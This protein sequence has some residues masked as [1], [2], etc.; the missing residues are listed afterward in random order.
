[1]PKH[2]A[3]LPAFPSY[4][5]HANHMVRRSIL[6]CQSVL[7]SPQDMTKFDSGENAGYEAISGEL[8][9]WLKAISSGGPQATVF[10]SRSAAHSNTLADFRG[11]R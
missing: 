9:K 2:S 8:F 3:I 4:G 6:F 7:I 1:M 10:P 11:E 5:I